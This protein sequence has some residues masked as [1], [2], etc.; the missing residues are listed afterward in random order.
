MIFSISKIAQWFFLFSLVA[1]PALG[2]E[3]E[4]PLSDPFRWSIE[5]SFGVSY[6]KLEAKVK[7]VKK[8]HPKDFPSQL[9][10]EELI[11]L[12]GY[13]QSLYRTVNGFLRQEETKTVGP[14]V[15]AMDAALAKLPKFKGEVVRATNMPA[16][17]A[18][19]YVVGENITIPA[20]ASAS[21]AG[22]RAGRDRF[23]IQSENARLLG[24]LS[25]FPQDREVI[26][27]RNTTFK[28]LSKKVNKDKTTEYT[29]QEVSSGNP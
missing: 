2:N 29:L 26:F 10:E 21:I 18:L 13:T 4:K 28:V 8:A 25:D 20:Y 9:T 6:A 24:V 15:K 14:Y 19:G 16:D 22:L 17:V 3:E 1:M 27:P 5:H 23:R 11:A 7:K 12:Y